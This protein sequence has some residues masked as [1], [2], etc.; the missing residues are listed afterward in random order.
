MF[1]CL[2]LFGAV[3]PFDA[4]VSDRTSAS[5]YDLVLTQKMFFVARSARLTASSARTYSSSTRA[6]CK[7]LVVGAGEPL[8]QNVDWTLKS[9]TSRV[10]AGS[11]G[12]TVSNQLYKRLADKGRKLN[13][14]DIVLV[15]PAGGW[16]AACIRLAIDLGMFQTGTITNLDGQ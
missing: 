9:L 3:S 14:G 13:Y 8:P 10:H 1:E 4:I 5:R 12:L 2:H 16:C 6:D 7:V 11:A 15:D